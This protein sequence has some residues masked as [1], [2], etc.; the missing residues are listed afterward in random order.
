MTALD[1]IFFLLVGLGLVFGVMRG[2]V[3]EVLSLGIWIL[4]V[5][6]LRLLHGPLSAALEPAIGTVSGAYV[7]A[8]ALIFLIVLVGGKLVVRRLGGA[9]R[10]SVIGP[11]DRILGGGFGALKG[12]VGVA[13]FYMAFSL[14][15]DTIWGR[16][17]RRPDWVAQARTYPVVH[18]AS[19]TIVDLVEARRNRRAGSADS[20][21]NEAEPSPE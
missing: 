14:V 4:V 19:S 13:L 1:I 8:F 3:H 5:I 6:A 15:Y 2:F 17:A 11:L 12:L 21:G 18:V 9:T 16:D 20:V 7:L 10:K